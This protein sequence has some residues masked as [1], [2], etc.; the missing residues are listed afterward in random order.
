MSGS[1]IVRKA[2]SQ[3]A[4]LTG[5]QPDTVSAFSHEDDG[6]HVTIEMVD[7]KRIPESTDVLESYE[8]VL[9]DDGDLVSYQRV[10][11]YQR[12]EVTVQVAERRAA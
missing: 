12:G 2:K 1:E 11:R 6:W 10:R 8:C 5:L 9:N 7:L 3:L 4:D